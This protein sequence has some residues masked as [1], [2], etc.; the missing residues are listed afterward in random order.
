VGYYTNQVNE[1][2]TWEN[3]ALELR[4]REAT[5]GRGVFKDLILTPS[6]KWLHYKEAT[7]REGGR[8]ERTQLEG[9]AFVNTTFRFR[10]YQTTGH[11]AHIF[12]TCT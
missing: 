9:E 12:S 10:P 6:G 4:E 5:P 8:H 2:H 3:D 1:E 7:I 11:F